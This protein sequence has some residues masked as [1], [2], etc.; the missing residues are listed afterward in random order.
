MDA[1]WMVNYTLRKQ[2]LQ[3]YV[4]THNTCIFCTYTHEARD[5]QF[6]YICSI[7]IAR[8]VHK[9]TSILRRVKGWILL[10]QNTQISD[11]VTSQRGYSQSNSY[12]NQ[13]KIPL[14]NNGCCKKPALHV[15]VLDCFIYAH[16][17][18]IS[19]TLLLLYLCLQATLREVQLIIGVTVS[20]LPG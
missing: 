11:D 20:L 15:V 13:C 17:N 19:H 5:L 4:Y 10:S 1:R 14:V 6:L 18:K 9:S 3:A 16:S 8:I 12:I 7:N 2:Q